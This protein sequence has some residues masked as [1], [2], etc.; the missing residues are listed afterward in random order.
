MKNLFSLFYAAIFAR[1]RFTQPRTSHRQR[2][3]RTRDNRA[4]SQRLK[5]AIVGGNW[6]GQEYLT[7]AEHDKIKREALLLNAP[8]EVVR[9][10][11]IAT[12]RAA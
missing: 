5:P 8:Y 3:H 11:Y 12:R 1:S 4:G 9:N 10:N 7:Y 6:Q 2:P